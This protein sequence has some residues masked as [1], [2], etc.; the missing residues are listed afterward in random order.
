MAASGRDMGIR[1]RGADN[2]L[3]GGFSR[4]IGQ[5]RGPPSLA[6]AALVVVTAVYERLFAALRRLACE[7]WAR[8][9]GVGLLR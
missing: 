3:R 4:R 1:G 7:D 9:N 8:R 6:V 2:A 5:I